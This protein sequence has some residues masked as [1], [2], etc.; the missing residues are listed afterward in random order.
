MLEKKPVIIILGPTAIGK[1]ELSIKIASDIE[2]EII[3]ADSMQI[4]KYMDIGTAK[5]SIKEM[6]GIN[7]YLID[8]LTPDTP[9]N[10]SMYQKDSI[11]AIQ[12]IHSKNKLPIIS[13]GTGLYI[14][15]L[16]YPYEFSYVGVD[17]LYR[18]NLY[19]RI[20]EEGHTWLHDKLSEVD[21]R[22]ANLIH[23][24]DKKRIIRALEIRHI[25]D[26]NNLKENEMK[27]DI[28]DDI[29]SNYHY[30]M[31]GLTTDR[32]ILYKRIENRVDQMINDG[33][34]IEVNKLLEM[35]YDSELNSLQ[36]LGYKEIISY[37]K[38]ERTLE[39][40]IYILKRD[41][42]RFAKRQMTWFNKIENVKWFNKN[43][44]FKYIEILDYI[45]KNIF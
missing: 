6:K 24:N 29:N 28:C 18:K 42:K 23:P 32:N 35:G 1:T 14:N 16:I 30:I 8:F 7:H 43:Q 27:L 4:Y 22:A 19:D 20:Q 17:N 12:T 45:K 38:G 9:Y 25:M 33:L 36:G 21:S 2:G 26:N 13:G 11:K 31:I 3:S 41:T 39:E 34:V 40:A 15:S 44:D 5:P 10:V 37:L